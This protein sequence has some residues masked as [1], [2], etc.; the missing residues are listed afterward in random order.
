M[1]RVIIIVR[2]SSLSMNAVYYRLED[3]DSNC[4]LSISLLIAFT[5]KKNWSGSQMFYSC[6]ALV[7]E[8]LRIELITVT[9][10][11]SLCN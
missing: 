1:N 8:N 2:N 7:L 10:S 9:S 6:L 11:L 4:F 5:T 3:K